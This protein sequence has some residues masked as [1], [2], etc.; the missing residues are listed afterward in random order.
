MLS[1]AL[2]RLLQAV[3]VFGGIVIICSILLGLAG[4]PV[5][6]L[7]PQRA[8]EAEL[9]RKRHELGL[10]RPWYS[11]VAHYASGDLGRSYRHE[12]PVFEMVWEGA[13]VTGLVALG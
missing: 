4:D 9:E 12:R 5:K 13:Q 3:P 8:T 7:M 11:R 2:G 1:Y 6:T 10:D